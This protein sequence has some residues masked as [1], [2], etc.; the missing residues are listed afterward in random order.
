[1]KNF[2]RF[3]RWLHKK[4]GGPEDI[5]RPLDEPGSRIWLL[6]D[7]E[8]TVL[9]ICR[10]MDQEFKEEI[11]P[12]LKKVRLFLERLLILNLIILN[13]PEDGEDEEGEEEGKEIED[14]PEGEGETE[15]EGEG[16]KEHGDVKEV[17]EDEGSGKEEC[18]A[19][20]SEECT[21]VITGGS[22]EGDAK[23]E[24]ESD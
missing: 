10:I 1:M 22:A 5:N 20:L 11:S 24:E 17:R 14:E 8:H 9:E 15:G 7:G 18:V 23:P 21:E 3:E 2:G 16:G 19:E 12:V 13:P 4:I 6:M